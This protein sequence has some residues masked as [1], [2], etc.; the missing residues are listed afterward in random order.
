MPGASPVVVVSHGLWQRRF[1]GRVECSRRDGRAVRLAY[2]IVGIGPI[3]F[4]GTVPGIPTDFWV[5]LMMVDRFEFAGVQASDDDDPGASRLERRGTRWLFL[6]GRLADGRRIEDARAEIETIFARLR[7]AYPVTNDKATASVLPASNIRFH[8]MLDGY[9]RAVSA[10]LL[11]AVS[12]V[13]LIACANVANMLLAR[14]AS[15]RRELAIRTAIGA[16]RARIVRQLLSEG[17]VLAAT[18]G[19]LGLIIAWWA[20]AR[21]RRLALACCQ[22]LSA[23]TCHSTRRS[24]MFAVGA[25]IATAILF[26][27]APA[28]SV[29][30]PELVPALKASMEGDAR[31]RVTLSNV[32]VVGQL[33]L[34]LVLLVAGAL[35]ARGLVTARAA[36][37]G[38][39]PRPVSQLSFNL[40]M[41]GYD[42]GRATDL[43][44]RALRALRALPGVSAVSTATRLPLSPD[45]NM[46]SILVQ[47]HHRPGDEGANINP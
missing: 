21:L 4:T 23:S 38:Y 28:W 26:G 40:Q 46:D 5:P 19:V 41:N 14:G 37:L 24:S 33:A 7:T 32:L 36:D 47:G 35:L 39:D 18:G 12:L 9:V 6:K 25:S 10:A 22:S 1:G 11:V 31:R 43:R 8:P 30:K 29:S 17:L 34:S 3:G 42:L 44:E 13:L 2:T 16:S 15:R 45:I 27:L 20:G